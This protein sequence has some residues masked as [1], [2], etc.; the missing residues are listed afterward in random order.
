MDVLEILHILSGEGD[1]SKYKLAESQLKDVED[2]NLPLYLHTMATQLANNDIP[3]PDRQVAGICL[4]NA[5]SHPRDHVA[6]MRKNQVWMHVDAAQRH[7][8]KQLA[9]GTLSVEDEVARHTAA[10][11]VAELGVIELQY[12]EWRDVV[13]VLLELCRNG[14]DYTRH[15]AIEALG[16]LCDGAKADTIG[17]DEANSILAALATGLAEDAPLPIRH[18]A[19]VALRNSVAY[20]KANF[21]VDEERTFIMKTVGEACASPDPAVQV[22]AFECLASI[23]S[24]YYNVMLD[25]MDGI[26]GLTMQAMTQGSEEVA[27]QG[28]EVWSSICDEE[29]DILDELDDPLV[30]DSRKRTCHYFVRYAV[31]ERPEFLPTITSMLTKQQ[32]DDYDEEAWTPAMAAGACLSLIAGTVGDDVVPRVMPFVYENVNHENWR[33]REAA[34]LAFGSILDGPAGTDIT[35]ILE[36][37]IPEFL[38]HMTDP[39]VQ[40]KDTTAWTLGRI[41][42]FHHDTVG[43]YLHQLINSMGEALTDEPRVACNAAWTLHTIANAYEDQADNKSSPISPYFADIVRALMTTSDREDADDCNLRVHSYEAINSVILAAP[44]DCFGDVQEFLPMFMSRMQDTF[45]PSVDRE[46]CNTLQAYISS[47]VTT[48]AQRLGREGIAPVADDLMGLFDR[49]F[50]G[51]NNAVHEEALAAVGAIA[52]ALEADFAVYYPTFHV[53]MMTALKNSEE[54]AVCLAAVGLVGD[55]SRCLGK[56]ILDYCDAILRAL[57]DNLRLPALSRDVKIVTIS[58]FGDIALAIR[59]DFTYYLPHIIDVLQDVSQMTV[60]D[61]ELLE[62]LNRLRE[63]V[64]DAYTG[65][66]QGLK[67]ENKGEAFLPHLKFLL[68]FIE[69]IWHDT[70]IDD[71]VVKNIVGIIGD[72]ACALGP[73]DPKVKGVLRAPIVNNILSKGYQMRDKSIANLAKWSN[74]QIDKL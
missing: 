50:Q 69:H 25:Y 65:I 60:A 3:G 18:V 2:G 31:T 33:C 13:E 53:H 37:A 27:L 38:S 62:F 8:I 56:R 68:E 11:V 1:Q 54:A 44:H 42:Q 15:G 7:E 46:E 45:D 41:V 14:T 35:D 48:I 63:A 59:G 43:D 19:I 72:I 12:D 40:V 29:S 64:L 26:Y 22:A 28:T 61:E 55:A 70:T 32:D 16:F 67:D 9:L 6:N 21:E 51:K 36:K 47:V 10:Q 58:C 39:A 30:P 4:K 74:K 71:R 73:L 34:A 24:R 5:V 17:Q 20:I 57:L 66:I 52:Q 23:V 49:V